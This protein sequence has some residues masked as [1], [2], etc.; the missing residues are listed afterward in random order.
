MGSMRLTAKAAKYKSTEV[1]APKEFKNKGDSSFTQT[2]KPTVQTL[3]PSTNNQKIYLRMLETEKLIIAS[4]C[5]GT[6]KT[7]VSCIYAANQIVLG[8]IDKIILV[9]PPVDVERGIGF[10]PGDKDDKLTPYMLPMIGYIKSVLGA[11]LYD[12]MLAD[13]RIIIQGLN[14]IRGM[15]FS[16]AFIICDEMQLATA[17]EIQ[18]LTTR[19][20]LNCTLV[21]CGDSNQND[22]KDFEKK[23]NKLD[24]ISYIKKIISKYGISSSGVVEFEIDDIIRS[25]MCR[26]FI[27]AYE[28]ES[29]V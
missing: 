11:E 12:E 7:Y 22:L 28:S 8:K 26:E 2:F 29:W 23:N 17:K 24:G 5:A 27:I 6:G 3:V 20:G 10:L 19:V 1:S 13:E 25:G 4:G 16:N 21:I 9:R 18:A 14:M 15:S